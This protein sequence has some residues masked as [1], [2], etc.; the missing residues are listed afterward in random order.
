MG[1]SQPVRKCNM[2]QFT[3]PLRSRAIDP[4]FLRRCA[5]HWRILKNR[6]QRA[7]VQAIAR[8]PSDSSPIIRFVDPLTEFVSQSFCGDTRPM[9]L[10]AACQCLG[11]RRHLGSQTFTQ[12]LHQVVHGEF[13]TRG[14]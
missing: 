4:D 5:R 11:T 9:R 7:G 8:P 1:L 12:R 13:I 3:A 10:H 6:S 14:A 2:R